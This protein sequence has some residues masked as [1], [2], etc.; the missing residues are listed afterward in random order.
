MSRIIDTELPVEIEVDAVHH[1][2]IRGS[3][4][5][6]GVP[7]EPDEPAHWEFNQVCIRSECRH[8][9]VVRSDITD[10]VYHDPELRQI[11]EQGLEDE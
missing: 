2:A 11:I 3:R 7:L 9:K 6:F 4:D 5:S 8:G 10:L 1:K